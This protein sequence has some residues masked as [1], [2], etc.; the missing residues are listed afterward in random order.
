MKAILS[1][2]PTIGTNGVLLGSTEGGNVG[3]SVRFGII[4]DR[5]SVSLDSVGLAC[6]CGDGVVND[7]VLPFCDVILVWV[8]NGD[9]V[10]CPLGWESQLTDN[11]ASPITT[12][13]IFLI[14]E[15]I[16]ELFQL[17]SLLKSLASQCQ[18]GGH[19]RLQ[20]LGEYNHSR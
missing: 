19:L 17:S 2:P 18:I 6:T 5:E 7:L 12:S 8:G 15:R 4:E 20:D 1:A 10:Y 9:T 13:I 14:L 11:K 3:V 16:W